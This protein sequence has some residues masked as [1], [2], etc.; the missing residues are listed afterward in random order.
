MGIFNRDKKQ[1]RKDKKVAKNLSSQH[2]NVLSEDSSFIVKE[3]YKSLRTNIMFSLSDDGC[4]TIAVSSALASEGKSINCLNLAISF[5]ETGVKVLLIDCDLRRPNVARLLN[6]K[7]SPGFSNVL[8]HR[9]SLSDVI[10]N[11]PYKNL[12]VIMT[13]D[14]A[15]NPVELLGSKTMEK[16]LA[17]LA[18][19]YDYIFLDTPPINLVTDTSILSK[20]VSGIILIVRQNETEKGALL[21][22]VNQL[23]FVGAK[24]LGFVLNGA[25][26]ELGQG[27][28]KYKE[29]E[30]KSHND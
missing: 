18:R 2:E 15:P 30:R 22:A 4:K 6:E 25:S 29:Y 5:A 27:A 28:Y 19:V 20:L 11:T 10:R 1:R 17:E 3:A 16:T 23:K 21:Y 9:N 8:V 26:E 14:L 12:E 7:A 24:I 13:G